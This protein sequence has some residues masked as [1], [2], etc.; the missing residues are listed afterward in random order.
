MS[1]SRIFDQLE[2]KLEQAHAAT[3]SIYTQYQDSIDKI[4]LLGNKSEGPNNFL[5]GV[6]ALKTLA[7]AARDNSICDIQN[8]ENEYLEELAH[9]QVSDAEQVR[10]TEHLNNYQ[11]LAYKADA[12]VKRIQSTIG[13]GNYLKEIND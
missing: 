5:D 1:T 10:F 11:E 7:V 4:K 8:I 12:E 3:L 6:V 13:F 9:G 2:Q